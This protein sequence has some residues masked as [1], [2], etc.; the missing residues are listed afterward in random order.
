MP[1]RAAAF[2]S[3]SVGWGLRNVSDLDA[4]FAEAFR[5]LKPGG[6]FVSLDMARPANGMVRGVSRLIFERLSPWLGGL[7][8][9]KEA[10]AYLPQSTLRFATREELR[11]AMERAGFVSVGWKDFMLGNICMHWGQKP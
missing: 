7:F 3:V 6:R 9:A 11:A 5:A 10:Y 8:G 2:D 4:A 1:V